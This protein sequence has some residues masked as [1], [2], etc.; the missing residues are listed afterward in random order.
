MRKAGGGLKFP[1]LERIP[2]GATLQ[3]PSALAARPSL[4]GARL[5]RA[6]VQPQLGAFPHGSLPPEPASPGPGAD[7][8][9][10]SFGLNVVTFTES[11]G[12]WKTG[13]QPESCF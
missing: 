1:G 9:H 4:L 5:H 13:L 7:T 12:A 10:S 2:W 11:W 6:R 8:S 3:G